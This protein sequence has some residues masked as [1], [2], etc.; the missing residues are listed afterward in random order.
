MTNTAL[1]FNPE[2]MISLDVPNGNTLEIGFIRITPELA[3]TWLNSNHS[4]QRKLSKATVA[5]Y[6][7]TIKNGLWYPDTGECIK[8]SC[9]NNIIDGQHRLNAIVQAGIPVT[10]LVIKNI[11][12]EHLAALDTGK[13]RT[14]SDVFTIHGVKPVKGINDNALASIVTGL[15]Y[16]CRYVK[17]AHNPS[18]EFRLDKS[19]GGHRP[20]VLQLFKFLENNPKILEHLKLLDDKKVSTIG[21]KFPV[22]GNILGWY[23]VSLIDENSANAILET[24]RTGIPVS[25]AGYDCPSMKLLSKIQENKMN[26]SFVRATEY[27]AMWLWTYEHMFDKKKPRNLRL[28]FSNMPGQGHV[29]SKRLIEELNTYKL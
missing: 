28:S 16:L 17:V 25:G 27:V 7:K 13:K 10:M 20:N 19:Q 21:N 8:I 12:D 2:Q 1:R 14:L 18:K 15:W 23:A 5:Q 9:E 26:K 24:L 29:G 22:S 6:T 3:N 11:S 4:N